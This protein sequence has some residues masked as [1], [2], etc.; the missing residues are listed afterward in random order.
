MHPQAP[1]E[2]VTFTG[3]YWN[4][5]ERLESLLTYVRPWFTNIVVVVQKSPDDT[6]KVAQDLADQ[7]FEDRWHGRGDPSIHRA[8]NKVKTRFAFVISDDERPSPDLLDS[9]QELAETLVAEGKD[10]AWI[11][12]HSSID[13]IDFT[14]EA[15]GH[16]RFF[17]PK[18]PWP[19]TPHARPMTD[20]TLFWDHGYVD[21]DR[22]LDEMMQDYVRRYDLTG[23]EPSWGQMQAHNVKMI[24]SASSAIGERKGWPYVKSFDWWPRVMDIAY[25]EDPENT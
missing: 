4:C 11:P 9:F 10:G 20:N 12:F 21:H 22:T 15:Q 7:V 17:S 8:V 18:I 14:K 24:R 16:L 6:L 13:G 23:K 1:W 25:D 19:S 5:A 3:A 2:D